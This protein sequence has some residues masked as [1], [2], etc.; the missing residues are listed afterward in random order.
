VREAH[1]RVSGAEVRCARPGDP[2][3][4]TRADTELLREG[5]VGQIGLI[6]RVGGDPKGFDCLEG[7]D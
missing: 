6:G 3:P 1:C 5:R 7:K 2:V 4:V